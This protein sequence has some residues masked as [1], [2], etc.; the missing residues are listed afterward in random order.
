MPI[1]LVLFLSMRYVY[2]QW[3][4]NCLVVFGICL[5][6]TLTKRLFMK[7]KVVSMGDGVIISSEPV[8]DGDFGLDPPTPTVMERNFAGSRISRSDNDFGQLSFDF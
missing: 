1:G 5:W 8:V 6:H 2:N 7:D 4:G 3:A